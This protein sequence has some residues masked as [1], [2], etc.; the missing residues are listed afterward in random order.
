MQVTSK[1]AAKECTADMFDAAQNFIY[2]MME[3]DSYHKF[4]TSDTFLQHQASEKRFKKKHR[5]KWRSHKRKTGLRK[6]E[7]KTES[8]VEMEQ[9]LINSN[10]SHKKKSKDSK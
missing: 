8:L 1:L 10:G 3:H 2:Q 7:K 6:H 9:Y 4:L 5:I